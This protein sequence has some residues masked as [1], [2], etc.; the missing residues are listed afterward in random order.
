M[1]S[2]SVDAKTFTEFPHYWEHCIGSSH[3]Y[4][5]LREDYR[6]QLKKVHDELG[7]KRVRF[8]GLFNDDMGVCQ[9]R[10]SPNPEDAKIIDYNFS[11]IDS[12]FDFLLEIGMKPF[13]EVADMPSCLAATNTKCFA[14]DM[15]TSPPADYEKW[16]LFIREFVEHLG[17]RYGKDE[18][19]KWHF[20][21]W[22]EPNNSMFWSGTKEQYFELYEN[23]SRVI[24][25]VCLEYQVGGPAT[26]CNMWI[27]EFIEYCEENHVPLDFITTHHYPADE[28]LW[29]RGNYSFEAMM[30]LLMSGEKRIFNRDIMKQMTQKARKDAK[31]YPLY[32]TEWNIS[33]SSTDSLHDDPY[34]AAM[35]AKILVGNA[36]L[37]QGY[38]Y[39]TFS[40]IFEELGQHAGP[41]HGGFGLVNY[42]GV[43]KPVYRCFEL[44]HN[45]GYKRFDVHAK[46]TDTTAEIVALEIENGMR[47]IIYNYITP[48]KPQE[49][50]TVEIKIPSG[51]TAEGATVTRID[52]TH[53]NPKAAWANMGAP[54]YL[55]N[56]ET[57]A[58][59]KASELIAEPYTSNIINVPPQ[60]IVAIDLMRK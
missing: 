19:K 50:Q 55:K 42:Y 31:E 29:K 47:L 9:A 20:E 16:N 34:S 23:T 58:L 60:G 51:Y 43:P 30:E 15:H 24:K 1:V 53:S 17:D 38:S 11:N 57:D 2:F 3:G 36:G 59:E 8:H 52:N 6:R 49:A 46:T 33:A 27:P 37:V 40:D 35:V 45:T 25:S 13:I 4:T 39:W 54:V 48:D 26:S 18:V 7:F 44:F 10:M 21:I 56:D 41:Y 28:T 12:I 14:W 5:A 22:N 32:Y